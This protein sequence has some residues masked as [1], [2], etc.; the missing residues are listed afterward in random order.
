[1]MSP[2]SA[3]PLKMI[4]LSF[5]ARKTHRGVM[6]MMM[7]IKPSVYSHT[8]LRRA[9]DMERSEN[10]PVSGLLAFPGLKEKRVACFSVY[11]I[12]VADKDGTSTLI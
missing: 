4:K 1:M 11:F 9:L 5:L 3:L 2:N 6:K 8:V 12:Y 7:S 10:S